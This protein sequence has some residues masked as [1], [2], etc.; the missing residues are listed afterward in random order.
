LQVNRRHT[1]TAAAKQEVED[2]ESKFALR[3]SGT[4]SGLE[5]GERG[6]AAA[7]FERRDRTAVPDEE[8]ARAVTNDPDRADV[9]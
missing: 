1:L 5:T 4:H 8:L 3:A 6:V 9:L 2:E 7:A